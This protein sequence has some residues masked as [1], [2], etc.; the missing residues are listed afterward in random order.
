MLEFRTRIEQSA[1]APRIGYGDQIVCMGSCFAE[2]IG[3]R[4]ASIKLQA[5]VN[6][7][8]ILYNPVSIAHA[9]ELSIDRAVLPDAE[10]ICHNGLWHSLSHHGK[11]SDEEKESLKTRISRVQAKTLEGLR[12]ATWLI[13]TLGTAN[14]FRYLETGSVV[15]NCHKV[16]A[17]RFSRERLSVEASEDAL[18]RIVRA[19]RKVNS[20]ISIL[21]TVSPV[22][23]IRDGLIENQRS[24]ATLLLAVDRICKLHRNVHYFPAYEAC[25]DDLRDYR[26]Y[27]DDLVHPSVMATEYIWQRF[28]EAIFSPAAIETGKEIMKLN[29]A[30]AHRPIGRSR[31]NIRAFANK[32]LQFIRD[33]EEKNPGIPFHEEKAYFESLPDSD[34]APDLY[35]G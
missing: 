8:G 25:M 33:L 17:A 18:E 20:D 3:K 14:V 23:H 21:F 5:H 2:E 22:R 6:S 13:V 35:L 24:K 4:L 29:R 1:L 31:D 10:V 26:F 19:T 12:K 16:P 7:L 15:A 27:A 11:F 9:L 28:T 32:Q 34:Q 30:V